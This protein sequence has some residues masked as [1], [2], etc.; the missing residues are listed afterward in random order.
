MT[1][2][3]QRLAELRARMSNAQR[4]QMAEVIQNEMRRR[5]MD[6]NDSRTESTAK[7]PRSSLSR[8]EVGE[9]YRDIGDAVKKI[10]VNKVDQK[11]SALRKKP[12]FE[13]PFKRA[14]A[15]STVEAAPARAER[16]PAQIA[17]ARRADSKLPRYVV[18][19][20]IV[21]LGFLK[22]MFES[23]VVDATTG[24]PGPVA[25]QM[26]ASQAEGRSAEKATADPVVQ[27][28]LSDGATP[29]DLKILQELDQRRVQLEARKDALD[30]RELDI[31]NQA[32][33]LTERIAE[34]RSLTAKLTDAH[35]QKDTRYEGRMGQ[36]ANVYGAM[37][38]QEAAALLARLENETAIELLQRMPEKR[39]GQILS[40]MEKERAVDLTRILSDRT[41]MQ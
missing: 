36:L 23:G 31:K 13:M 12:G 9:L 30:R 38:P 41:T 16:L 37:S 15:K 1:N 10:R 2:E 40:F 32:Q 33:A 19:T 5:G 20:G 22:I 25:Q 34:L 26:F 6:M 18:F 4:Q 8:D 39:M 27:L 3:E 7:A 21:A 24:A 17:P 35:A 11:L 28:K 29:V 14:R